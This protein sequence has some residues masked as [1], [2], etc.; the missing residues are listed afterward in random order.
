MTEKEEGN[1]KRKKWRKE[2]VHTAACTYM[3]QGFE[4]FVVSGLIIPSELN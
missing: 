3:N 2:C 1:K 4:A